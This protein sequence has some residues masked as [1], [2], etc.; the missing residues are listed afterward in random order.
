M[1]HHAAPHII[2]WMVETEIPE[3]KILTK[4]DVVKVSP[5]FKGLPENL[6]SIPEGLAVE[7][8]YDRD[9]MVFSEGD[10]NGKLFL[11]ASGAI[12]IY[13]TSADGKEQIIA[14][15][16]P[17]DSFNDVAAFDGGETQS[18]AQ[19]LTPVIV[20]SITGRTLL[21][22]SCQLD[23]LAAN[24]IRALAF[25]MRQLGDLVSDLSFR[26]VVGRLA[27]ILLAQVD[28]PHRLHLTQRDMAAMA[29]TAREVLARALK[30]ME[31]QGIVQVAGHRI[32][33]LDR[34]A[35]ERMVV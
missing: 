29:G 6:F 32:E 16:R 26:P 31:N 12:K 13:G 27:K 9:A 4:R 19:A 35:L 10:V 3:L 23:H 22:K 15:A 20:Y 33:I 21:E 18:S 14:L 34:A 17:G 7:E 11:V 30:A 2:C 24:I 5:Y 1:P 8:R 28:D 25:R